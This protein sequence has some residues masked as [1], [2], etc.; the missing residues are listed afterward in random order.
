[1]PARRAAGAIAVPSHPAGACF[2]APGRPRRPVPRAGARR[3]RARRC[4]RRWCSGCVV[5]T[6]PGLGRPARCRGKSV[7]AR[8]AGAR[9]GPAAGAPGRPCRPGCVRPRRAAGWP[10]APS[11]AAGFR[12]GAGWKM[13]AGPQTLPRRAAVRPGCVRVAPAR[14]SAQARPK[15]PRL[16]P[17]CRRPG[18]GRAPGPRAHRGWRPALARLPA[19]RRCRSAPRPC[20]QKC[21]ASRAAPAIR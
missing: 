1:M 21:P 18:P 19:L 6:L 12:A 9:P 7:F 16:P 13:A 15:P 10:A 8:P 5:Q 11:G 3:L 2:L 4:R 14:S 20:R 17:R